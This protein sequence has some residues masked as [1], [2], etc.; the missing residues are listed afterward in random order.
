[1][2]GS[3]ESLCSGNE[4]AC[5]L[6]DRDKSNKK[7]TIKEKDKIPFLFSTVLDDKFKSYFVF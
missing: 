2:V 4:V 6:N 7:F 1:M 3:L 5:G